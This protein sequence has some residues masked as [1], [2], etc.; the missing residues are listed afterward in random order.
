MCLPHMDTADRV[1]RKLKENELEE[2]KTSMIRNLL[3]K[4]SLHKFRF[5]KRWFIVAVDGSRVLSFSEKHCE[6][7]THTTSKNGKTTYFHRSS[8]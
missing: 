8:I 3:E 5:L 2:L 7:C 6:H 4:R 1:M